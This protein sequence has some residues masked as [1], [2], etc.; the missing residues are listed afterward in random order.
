MHDKIAAAK[1]G[2][3]RYLPYDLPEPTLANL[4]AIVLG[5][6]RI[7][8]LL[9]QIIFKLARIDSDDGYLLLGD[10]FFPEKL[11]RLRHL[12]KKRGIDSQVDK[13]REIHKSIER[14]IAV[15]NSIAHGVYKGR[16]TN[17]ASLLFVMPTK[18]P[19]PQQGVTRLRIDAHSETRL[20]KM[21]KN[22]NNTVR[23][24]ENILESVTVAS[25]TKAAA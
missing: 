6:A 16:D 9:S 10:I 8:D 7:S 11:R 25:E 12:L 14:I 15:R 22:L 2:D 19:D 21:A 3:R 5:A 4:A 13:L 1:I 17:G 24:V 23:A 18:N 20:S